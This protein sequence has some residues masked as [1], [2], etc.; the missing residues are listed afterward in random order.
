MN[1]FGF[2][3]RIWSV[4]IDAQNVQTYGMWHGDHTILLKYFEHRVDILTKE[5]IL[6]DFERIS[7]K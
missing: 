1:T 2:G 5:V 6:E 7:K 4:L 3:F